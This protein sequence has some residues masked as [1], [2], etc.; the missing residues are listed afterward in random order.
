VSFELVERTAPHALAGVVRRYA[1]FRE[2]IGEPVRRREPAS[3]SVPLILN[4]GPALRVGGA[5]APAFEVGSF[6]AP[7]TDGYAIT[8]TGTFSYGLQ[9]DLTPL[10]AY[11]VL[12]VPMG[13]LTDLVVP[14]D[15]LLGTE[16]PLLEEELFLA[17]DWPARFR[18]LDRF[19]L[20]RIERGRAPSPEVAWG[21]RR[22]EHSR[23][24]L[25]VGRL[26][27]EL[28]CSRRHLSARFREQV[29]VAPKTAARILRFREAAG[30]LAAADGQSLAGIAHAC[31][32]YDQAHLN[33]DF[34]KMAGAS[35]GSFLAARRPDGGIAA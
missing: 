20:R 5:G 6:A 17:A 24:R 1:G 27:A 23:G 8:E 35:P 28:G 3:E 12:G 10:G 30:L 2:Q 9:V 4:F 13:E 33:R 19:I 18:V 15:D 29:G 22:L 21:W 7:L 11:T 31:G 14:L 16:L 26:A 32:Y 34:R 25:P